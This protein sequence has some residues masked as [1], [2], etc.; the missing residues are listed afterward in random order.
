MGEKKLLHKKARCT[1]HNLD[2]VN[3]LETII[4]KI[5]GLALIL[6]LGELFVAITVNVV[7]PKPN[8]GILLCPC[9]YSINYVKV[10]METCC[11]LYLIQLKDLQ[12]LRQKT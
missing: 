10:L 4:K 2:D 9:R 12:T 1:Y 5:A 6:Q 7:W 8:K 11:K 3:F